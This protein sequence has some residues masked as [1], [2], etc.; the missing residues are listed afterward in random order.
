MELFI[1]MK[2]NFKFR[3]TNVSV[4]AIL[5]GLIVVA[6]SSTIYAQQKVWTLRDCIDYALDNNIQIKKSEISSEN[7]ESILLQRKLQ[8]LPSLNGYTN[9]KMQDGNPRK[10]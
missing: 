10:V 4:K 7:N 9:Y 3:L 5:I 8:I 2:Q 6:V 1:E